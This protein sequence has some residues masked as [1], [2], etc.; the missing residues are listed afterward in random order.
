LVSFG[1]IVV[2]GAASTHRQMRPRVAG[3]MLVA[4]G[5]RGLSLVWGKEL[6]AKVQKNTSLYI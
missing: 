2:L 5:G 3:G 1:A 4:V 6:S